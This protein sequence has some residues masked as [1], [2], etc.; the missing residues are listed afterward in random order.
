M[1]ISVTPCGAAVNGTLVVCGNIGRSCGAALNGTLVVC[2]GAGAGIVEA[3]V[4]CLGAL[5]DHGSC[6]GSRMAVGGDSERARSPLNKGA[7]LGLLAI[8]C[9]S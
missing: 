7:S 4:G 6:H 5:V 3:G 9:I 2:G 8:E 1:E